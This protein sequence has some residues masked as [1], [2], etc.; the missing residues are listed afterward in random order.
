MD[1]YKNLIER[2][3]KGNYAINEIFEAAD[4]IETLVRERDE[5]RAQPD[6]FHGAVGALADGLREVREKVKSREKP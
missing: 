6:V 2:L 5:A 4:A 1:D 3:R